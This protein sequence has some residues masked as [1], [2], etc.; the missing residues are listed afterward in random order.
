[1][2]N[3]NGVGHGEANGAAEPRKSQW[4]GAGKMLSKMGR[5]E[6]SKRIGGGYK[7]GYE[8]GTRLIS[9]DSSGKKLGNRGGGYL[10]PENKTVEG[11]DFVIRR[12]QGYVGRK[13]SC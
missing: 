10:V 5:D 11:A 6:G 4:K 9:G 1:M 13:S 12:A 7:T 8:L 2:K 3:K